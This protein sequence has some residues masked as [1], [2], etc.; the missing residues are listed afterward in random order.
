MRATPRR[1]RSRTQP[2]LTEQARRAQIVAAA[3]ETIVEL[4]YPRAS[5][6]QIAKRAGL[7]ST[8]LISYHFTS[9]KDLDWAVV[10]EV[11]ARLE[12]HMTIAMSDVSGPQAALV[13]YIEGLIDFMRRDPNALRAMVGVVMHG[14]V[15][16]DAGSEIAATEG[17]SAILEWGQREGVFR[18]FNVHVM[19]TTIQRSLDGIPLAQSVDEHLDLDQYARELVMLFTLATQAQRI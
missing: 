2:S 9:K 16:Y 12:A 10:T 6:A 11:Y 17:I 4:G 14:G 13:A 3:I 1:Q 18:A 19:A 7:S 15:S 8:G 5:F